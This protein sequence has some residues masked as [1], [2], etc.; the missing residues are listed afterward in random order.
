[1]PGRLAGK[2]AVVT[3]ASRGL[4]RAIALAY[5]VEGAGVVL[6]ARPS[7]S[8][9]E[10]TQD[11]D[12]L[13]VPCMA[14]ATD[15]RDEAD[16]VRLAQQV[17]EAFGRL[18][19]LVNNAGVGMA[20]TIRRRVESSVLDVEPAAWDA[21][22][23]T[24]V[25]G[26]FLVTRALL[27]TMLRREGGSVINVTSGLAERIVPGTGPYAASKSAVNQLT[28]VLAQELRTRGVRVNALHPG[29]VVDTALVP[30]WVPE[31]A[32]R[33]M[34]RP[35]V[36][37]PAAVWLASDESAGVTGQVIDARAWNEARGIRIGLPEE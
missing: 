7:P 2:V 28:R 29:G 30:S 4:G 18:D 9:I 25:R 12:A 36:I 14:V 1:M 26:V 32:R 8:L 19:V 16:C 5:A 10:T 6:A 34:L 13:G 31:D 15:V 20:V 24:N 11:V 22:F 37:C 33:R 35:P 27:P 21:I 3:G 23:A 17:N